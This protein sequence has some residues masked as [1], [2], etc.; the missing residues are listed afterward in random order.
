MA[1]WSFV[2]ETNPALGGSVFLKVTQ[3]RRAVKNDRPLF[4][5]EA[6]ALRQ[7]VRLQQL[8]F[9]CKAQSWLTQSLI[10]Q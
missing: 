7:L 4:L 6:G 5:Q 2:C 3:E 1:G 9:V 10:Q 8:S